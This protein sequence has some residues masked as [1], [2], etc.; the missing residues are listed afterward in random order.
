MG[1]II[2]TGLIVL[3]G[4]VAVFIAGCVNNPANPTTVPSAR[5]D[6]NVW[7]ERT[8]S[9]DSLG[10]YEGWSDSD[11]SHQEEY[12]AGEGWKFIVLDMHVYNTAN[13]SRIF[14]YP[15]IIDEAGVEYYPVILEGYAHF[16]YYQN[17]EYLKEK[18]AFGYWWCSNLWLG[19]KSSLV[20]TS[21][22]VFGEGG[23]S[24]YITIVYKIPTNESPAK[25]YY[26]VCD[27]EGILLNIASKDLEK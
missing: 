21:K 22:S 15:R 16:S 20:L 7:I 25:F 27:S 10:Y 4:I 12:K 14:K 13:E 11:L 17:D 24:R 8:W 2:T 3:V 23:M 1:K 19:S 26:Q 6:V 5:D 9:T 18:Y